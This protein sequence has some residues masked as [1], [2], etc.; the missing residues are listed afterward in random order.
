V[1]HYV[2]PI[3]NY[4][5]DLDEALRRVM[6]PTLVLELAVPAEDLLG[7]PGLD[8]CACMRD[9]RIVTLRCDDRELLQCRPADLAKALHDFCPREVAT[10]A[11]ERATE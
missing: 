7:S 10:G 5:F 4:A 1:Q 6:A 9:A 3:L 11:M 8:I 2:R